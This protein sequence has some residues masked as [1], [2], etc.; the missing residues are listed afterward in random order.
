[1]R[2]AK[3]KALKVATSEPVASLAQ[4]AEALSLPL[5][6]IRAIT[7][8]LGGACGAK[9]EA[10]VELYAAVLARKAR[11]PSRSKNHTRPRRR[12][13]SAAPSRRR[14]VPR[15]HPQV[16]AQR[17]F[18]ATLMKRS[19]SAGRAPGPDDPRVLSASVYSPHPSWEVRNM[20]PAFAP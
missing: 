4:I 11:D 17:I 2:L 5:T 14:P 1:M 18:A 12:G 13:D 3:G 16:L 6:D 19:Q 9:L 7:P 8:P 10:S 15:P 20:S